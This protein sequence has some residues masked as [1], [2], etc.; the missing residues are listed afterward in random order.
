MLAQ[1]IK[2]TVFIA[3]IVFFS[4]YIWQ[5]AYAFGIIA[6]LLGSWLTLMSYLWASCS[7][8]MSLGLVLNSLLLFLVILKVYRIFKN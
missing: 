3:L 8:A 5:L 6:W 4:F 7:I 2:Y 1:G